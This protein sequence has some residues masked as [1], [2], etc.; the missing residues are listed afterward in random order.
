ML[1][2]IDSSIEMYL[3]LNQTLSYPPGIINLWNIYP[4]ITYYCIDN[5][6][7]TF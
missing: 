2:I 1:A 4:T 3:S 6:Q 7:F 5:L